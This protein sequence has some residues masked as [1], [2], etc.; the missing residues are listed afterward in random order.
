MVDRADSALR[1]AARVVAL[2]L[3]LAV[4]AALAFRTVVY[5]RRHTVDVLF[6]DQWDFLEPL[7]RGAGPWTQFDWQHGPHRQGL[8]GLLLAWMLPASG[9]SI[10]TE[11]LVSALIVIAAAAIAWGTLRRAIGARSWTDVLAPLLCL[12]GGLQEIFVG[13]SNPAH[14]PLPMALVFALAVAWTVRSPLVR[15]VLCVVLG[16]FCV[17]TGFGLFMGLVQPVLF[18]AE[19]VHGRGDAHRR[20]TATLGLVLSAVILAA[21]FAGWHFL[22]A[23]DCFQ[24]PHPRPREYLDYLG[25]LLCRPLGMHRLGAGRTW[26]ARGVALAALA[27]AGWMLVRLF[28]R[29]EMPG[30]VVV[31]LLGFTCLFALNTTLGRVC[32]GF[33]T[34]GTSR[35]VPYVVPGWI[36]VVIAVRCWVH[37]PVVRWGLLGTVLIL[38]TVR[39]LNVRG[40]EAMGNHFAEGKRRWVACYRQRH[41]LRACDL[42]TSFPLHPTP[43]ATRMQEKLD[44]LEARRLNLFRLP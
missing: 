14:G 37:R 19:W 27:F 23:V 32:T 17:F 40:D 20:R 33:E 3:P 9:W 34:A 11:T 5:V 42:E 44:Y 2:A 15:T 35:Y 28:R 24:F 4:L 12:G 7:F 10:R 36:A 1:S 25:F 39:T 18:A 29:D 21:F 30:R 38:I 31:L 8:G 41:D 6:W 26:L 16:A 22:T 43:A 13:A